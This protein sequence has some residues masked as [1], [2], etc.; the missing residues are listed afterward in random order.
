MARSPRLHQTPSAYSG[1]ALEGG[2]FSIEIPYVICQ[3]SRGAMRGD[4]VSSA[5]RNNARA[6]NAIFRVRGEGKSSLTGHVLKTILGFKR[7]SPQKERTEKR[8][9]SSSKLGR[10]QSWGRALD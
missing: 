5:G 1:E 2:H 10:G 9:G 8:S 4:S 7:G 6:R 3:E